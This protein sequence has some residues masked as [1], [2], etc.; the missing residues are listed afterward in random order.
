M[1]NSLAYTKG[2]GQVAF[3]KCTSSCAKGRGQVA[4]GF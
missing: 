3:L 1:I 4:F 2:R